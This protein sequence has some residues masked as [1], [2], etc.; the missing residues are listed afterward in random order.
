MLTFVYGSR[1][2]VTILILC[3][4]Y[5]VKTVSVGDIRLDISALHSSATSEC[6]HTVG[7]PLSVQFFVVVT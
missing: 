5:V 3:C 1:I 7:W 2:S 6:L 4:S